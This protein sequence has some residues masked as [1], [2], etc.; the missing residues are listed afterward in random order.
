MIDKPIRSWKDLLREDLS[1][2]VTVPEITTT[3]GPA[4]IVM[5][6]RAFGGGIDN[7]EP[8]WEKMAELV[9]SLVTTYSRSSDLVS[10]LQQGE[11][12]AAPYTNFAWGM[13]KDTGQP[14]KRV[15][16]EEG[17]VGAQ[18]V[19]SI[20]KG[21]DNSELAHKYIDFIISKNVQEAQAMDLVDSPTNRLVE[22]PAEVGDMLVYGEDQ[23]DSLVFLDQRKLKEKQEEWI[24]RWNQVVSQ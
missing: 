5:L 14:V 22:L 20:V 12:W 7:P 4:T 13:I 11:V 19:V 8:G 21:T 17:F 6:A 9:D 16:P 24:E 15:I 3:F 23:I 1:G 10:Y 2:Y 18:S